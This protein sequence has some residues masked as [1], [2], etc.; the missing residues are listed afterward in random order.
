MWMPLMD[1]PRSMGTMVFACGSHA[2]G[3]LTDLAISGDS[4]TFFDQ[5]VKDRGY[6]LASYDLAAGDATFHSGW[7]AHTTHP[8]AGSVEREV[9]TIIYYADGATIEEPETTIRR[10]DMEAFHPGQ[11]PG[12]RA[13]SALNPVLYSADE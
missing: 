9:M 6:T 7:T 5:L 10:I 8:N 1:V 4:D 2:H 3:P 12:E 13:A 11:R